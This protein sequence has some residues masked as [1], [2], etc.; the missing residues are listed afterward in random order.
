MF[1]THV[2]QYI[3]IIMSTN[4]QTQN[5]V[6]RQVGFPQPLFE[7]IKI[8]L[9]QLGISTPEYVRH[10]VIEDI[11]PLYKDIPM[12]DLETEESIGRALDDIETGKVTRLKSTSAIKDHLNKISK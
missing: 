5:T 8:R 9:E 12:V 6:I 4:N 7:L 1:A 3:Y 11:K 2:L 10:L